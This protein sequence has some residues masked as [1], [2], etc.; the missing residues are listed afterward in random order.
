MT[1]MGPEE[2]MFRECRSFNPHVISPPMPPNSQCRATVV[3]L[4]VGGQ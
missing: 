1:M 3:G 4:L 2:A